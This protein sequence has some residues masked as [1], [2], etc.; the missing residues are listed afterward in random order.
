MTVEAVED[1]RH[2]VTAV[3]ETIEKTTLGNWQTGTAVNLER[4]LALGERMDGHLVQGHVDGLGRCISFGT[5]D[6]S[7]TYRFE[8]DKKFSALIVEKGSISL[9]GISL[10]VFDVK[11]NQFSVAI[12]PY[13]YTHTTLSS[14]TPDSKVNIEFDIIGKYVLRNEEL[15]NSA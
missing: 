10:T 5:L 1:N 12:I 3:P 4:C 7:W 6:G 2:R 9:N 13:T 8:I 14:V 11:E 15:R